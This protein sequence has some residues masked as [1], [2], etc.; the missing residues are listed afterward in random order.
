VGE[1]KGEYEGDETEV[2]WWR[3]GKESIIICPG[4]PA[5][6]P[7]AVDWEARASA[8]LQRSEQ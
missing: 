7:V 1:E 4:Y 2:R 6:A 5:A 3:P 8:F